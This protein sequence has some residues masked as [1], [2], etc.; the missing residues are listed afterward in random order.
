MIFILYFDKGYFKW[1]KYFLKSLVKHEPEVKIVIFGFN[2]TLLQINYLE[3]FDE[4][5]EVINEKLKFDPEKSDLWRFQL[6]CQK[7]WFVLETM[8]KY[9]GEGLY[10]ISDVDMLVINPLDRVKQ[11]MIGNDIGLIPVGENKVPSGFLVFKETAKV[12]LEDYH[13][14]VYVEG[15]LY[16]S[17]D[18]TTLAK[19]YKEYNNK[20]KFLELSRKYIDHELKLD[21]YIWSAHKRNFGEKETRFKL[22]SSVTNPNNTEADWKRYLKNWKKKNINLVEEKRK[23][24][25]EWSRRLKLA[26]VARANALLA[27]QRARK[28]RKKSLRA[29]PHLAKIEAA[30]A[31]K[32]ARKAEKAEKRAEEAKVLKEKAERKAK[33][34]AAL[35]GE[36]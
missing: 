14:R 27:K 7:C 15:R 11:G 20:L 28:L 6:V 24:K 5:I 19:L 34:E 17:K 29:S 18:Q 13:R 9:P 25:K 10:T 33:Q 23:H 26:R 8:R 2:L 16:R 36:K 22:F 35:G 30:R 3:E 4:V 21:S 31:A 32:M 1:S 12:F